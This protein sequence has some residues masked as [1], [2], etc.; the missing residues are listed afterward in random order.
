L[1]YITTLFA[2]NQ[3]VAMLE[4]ESAMKI[5]VNGGNNALV[6]GHF[7]VFAAAQL[8]LLPNICFR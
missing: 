8:R 3:S 2:W 7:R 5:I 6:A 1:T 4:A